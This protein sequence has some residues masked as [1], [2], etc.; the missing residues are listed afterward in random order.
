MEERTQTQ[1]DEK[2]VKSTVIRRRKTVLEMVPEAPP[3]DTVGPEVFSQS[4]SLAGSGVQGTESLAK[5]T[6]P[7]AAPGQVV[8]Q[9]QAT[10]E[11]RKILLPGQKIEPEVEAKLSPLEEEEKAEAEKKAKLKKGV[12][13][14]EDPLA[15]E[16]DGIGKVASIAQ[17]T[18]LA[19]VNPLGMLDRGIERVFQPSKASKKKKIIS[20]KGQQKTQITISKPIKRIVEVQG[21]IA[22]GDLAKT[23][24]VKASEVIKKLMGMGLMATLNQALDF[25]TA[26]LIAQE[27]QFEIK[28]VSFSESKIL[29]SLDKDIQKTETHRPPVVTVMGHVDHGKTSLLDAIRQ[30]NVTAGEAGGITQHI[31]AYTVTLPKGKITFLDTPG[32]EAFTSMRARGASVTDLVVLVVAA[33]DGVMPQTIESIH[34]AKAAGVPLVVAVNKIDRP[35]ANLDRIKRQLADQGLTPEDWGGDTLYCLVSAKQKKGIEELLESILLQAEV[36]ELKAATNVQARGIVLEAR[37]DRAR[38]PVATVLVQEGTLKAGDLVV[39]GA[40]MGRVRAM[41]DHLGQPVHEAPPSH[42]VEILGLE[43][44]PMAS[45]PFHVFEDEAKGKELLEHRVALKKKAEMAPQTKVS[46]ED[47]FAQSKAKIL[48]ELV[49]IVKADVQ[50]SLEAVSEALKKLPTDKVKIK[51]LHGAVGGVTESDVLL[52]SASNAVI[53]GFNVRPETKALSIAKSEGVQIK[54]YKIIYEMVSDIKLAMAGKL[55]PTKKE[56]Y[57][58]RVEVRQV[59]MVSKVGNVGGCYVIDGKITRNGHL[60]LLRDNIVVYEGKIGTLKRFKDDVR[61]VLQGFEC[62]MA[63]E[64]YQDIKP[65]DVIEAFEIELVAQEL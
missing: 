51:M 26:I 34:H 61:E 39:A 16:V 41:I 2:R 25:D 20:R 15:V 23:M 36:L 38:G 57:L 19:T 44:V 52:A 58:G 1:I 5:T 62:G 33:D 30:T 4:A 56:K 49:V 63:I 7:H 48:E 53:I 55:A 17:L 37:L 43:E 40:T 65:G 54:L 18:R 10:V 11:K 22:V 29:E 59:F 27:Y 9:A 47:F 14:K 50:G 64:G 12:K 42:A 13:K 31:G 24:G 60:R 21:S 45:D 3:I 28:D 35:E 6:V 32:H 8:S 46:L